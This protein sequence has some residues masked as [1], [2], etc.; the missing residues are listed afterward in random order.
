M[1]LWLS[2]FLVGIVATLVGMAIVY[3][4]LMKRA[5]FEPYSEEE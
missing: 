4:L 2:G 5:Y 3:T 1:M